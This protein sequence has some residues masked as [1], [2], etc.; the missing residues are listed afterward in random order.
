MLTAFIFLNSFSNFSFLTQILPM[1]SKVTETEFLPDPS[2]QIE[3][4][5]LDHEP[6]NVPEEG[7]RKS[8]KML[9][10]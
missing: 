4:D 8:N 1:Q 10:Q 2:I 3:D 5:G 6:E 7:A 9:L